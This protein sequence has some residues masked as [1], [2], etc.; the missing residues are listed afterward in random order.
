MMK[1]M[2]KK[3]YV[4]GGLIIAGLLLVGVICYVYRG[5][6]RQEMIP[7]LVDRKHAPKVDQAFDARI[8]PILEQLKQYELI[9]SYTTKTPTQCSAVA[10]SW[11]GESVKCERMA[12]VDTQSVDELLKSGWR[13]TIR[14]FYEKK[15]L[16]N[17]WLWNG[18]GTHTVSQLDL[19]LDKPDRSISF[20][21]EQDEV[22]CSLSFSHQHLEIKDETTLKVYAKCQ[23]W[24]KVFGG[25]PEH[26][27]P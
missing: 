17:G 27:N 19:L 22:A 8:A 5:A 11:V 21:N 6:I 24:V 12:Y 23:K 14:D 10:Y 15:L 18:S 7:S 9:D 1:K 16:T 3:R 4:V 26:L 20:S 25:F 2:I 13:N